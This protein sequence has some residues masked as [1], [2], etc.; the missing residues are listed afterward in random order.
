MTI[1]IAVPRTTARTRSVTLVLHAALQGKFRVALIGPS[2]SCVTAKTLIRHGRRGLNRVQL[3]PSEVHGLKAG[4]Y[5]VRVPVRDRSK[6]LVTAIT[7]THNRKIVPSTGAA[8]LEQACARTI[9]PV[10]TSGDQAAAA[11]HAPASAHPQASSSTHRHRFS[12][13]P[14]AIRNAIREGTTHAA[15]AAATAASSTLLALVF[16]SV[17]C[18]G[19]LFLMFP[20]ARLIHDK[21]KSRL[22]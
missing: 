13:L 9:L 3:G 19:G 17:L 5:L 12:L 16:V 18:L 22:S 8:R 2:P 21:R 14:R 1:A 7:I 4:R 15:H 6:P 10:A 20:V 11:A